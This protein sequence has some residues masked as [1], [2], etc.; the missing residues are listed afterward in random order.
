M[1]IVFFLFYFR[2]IAL[3]CDF[4]IREMVPLCT[5]HIPFQST[6][7]RKYVILVS[8]NKFEPV[9]SRP[10]V[11]FRSSCFSDESCVP[12]EFISLLN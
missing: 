4:K 11:T 3:S 1:V 2:D 10:E 6:L 7:N 12:V 9:R 8:V 5:L